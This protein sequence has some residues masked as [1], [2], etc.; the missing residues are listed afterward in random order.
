MEGV[1]IEV[2]ARV[3]GSLLARGGTVGEVDLRRYSTYA[4]E[5]ALIFVEEGEKYMSGE[6]GA[7][8]EERG[9]GVRDQPGEVHPILQ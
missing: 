8:E 7:I 6:E 3:Y 9:N 4:W 2:A 5:A 1:I